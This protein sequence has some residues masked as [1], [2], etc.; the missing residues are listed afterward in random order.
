MQLPA[1]L[2]L[3]LLATLDV[4]LV[5][6]SVTAAARRLGITQPAVSHKLRRL[7]E[8]LGDPLFVA[9]PRGLVPTE[10]AVALA[11][12]LRLALE[13][14]GAALGEPRPFDPATAQQ[15]FTLS[16]ADLFEF[17][18]LPRLLAV[19]AAEAP[20][21]TLAVQPRQP[22]LFERM[23]RGEVHFGFGPGF[24][25][26]AGLRQLKLEDEPFVVM[27]RAGHPLLRRPLTLERYLDA[28]HLLIA[29]N[30]R[31]GGFVDDALARL[32]RTRR[33]A[34]RVAHFAPAPFLVAQSD[35]LLTAPRSLGRAAAEH[36]ALSK[37]PLPLDVPPAP[38]RLAWH[39]RFDRDPGH[40]WL[41]AAIR[42]FMV[43]PPT[44]GAAV[45][46]R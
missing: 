17:A 24:S 9:G 26:R 36:V 13:Q 18:G 25:E 12:P 5:E 1:G 34:L 31:P 37:R 3:N 29:P 38:S 20:G 43:T 16:G 28:D 8:V 15:A 35:L 39:E 33:V 7:R 42:R 11:R 22:D 45:T 2:D 6:G 4:L 27:A 32:G 21:V 14:L 41:R 40:A 23:E 46:R 19:L 30:G 10:R 44:R